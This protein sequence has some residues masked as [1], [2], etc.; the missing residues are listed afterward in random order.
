MF[1]E[2]YTRNRQESRF[3]WENRPGELDFNPDLAAK[4]L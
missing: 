4:A 2:K 1:P 3:S